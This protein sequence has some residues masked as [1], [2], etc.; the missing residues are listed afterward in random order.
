MPDE[1]GQRPDPVRVGTTLRGLTEVA[2][3]HSLP[4]A[5]TDILHR[6]PSPPS[7]TPTQARASA[8]GGYE[9]WP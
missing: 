2:A 4:M 6:M 1:Q 5:R 7:S 9:H 3:G 8:A